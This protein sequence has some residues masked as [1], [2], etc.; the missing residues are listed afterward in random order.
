MKSIAQK[1]A[2]I[3]QWRGHRVFAVQHMPSVR[4][5]DV[6]PIA[7][8]AQRLLNA[9]AVKGLQAVSKRIADLFR[10]DPFLARQRFVMLLDVVVLQPR[11]RC[12]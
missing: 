9:P 7:R 4:G 1:C 2:R 11:K 12:H 6:Q 3:P 10:T 5:D 8:V